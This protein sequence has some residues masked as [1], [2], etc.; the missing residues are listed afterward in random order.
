[1]KTGKWAKF[2]FSLTDILFFGKIKKERPRI[3]IQK[4][5]KKAFTF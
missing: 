2:R 5:N 3:E 1:V 4:T